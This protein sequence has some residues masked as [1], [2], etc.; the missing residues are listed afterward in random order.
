[1]NIFEKLILSL[2]DKQIVRTKNDLKYVLIKEIGLNENL[3]ENIV[4]NCCEKHIDK[5]KKEDL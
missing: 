4:E 3:V 5:R 1:M 2:I